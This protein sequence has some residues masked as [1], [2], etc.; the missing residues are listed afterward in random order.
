MSGHVSDDSEL[1]SLSPNRH[2]TS[3]AVQPMSDFD[4]FSL[5]CLSH[6]AEAGWRHT[7]TPRRPSE[8]PPAHRWLAAWRYRV[9]DREGNSLPLPLIISL[10]VVDASVDWQRL[11]CPLQCNPSELD[12]CEDLSD[13]QS[14]N[15]CG[16]LHTLTSR[17]KANMPLTQAG[18][19]LVN[20]WPPLQTNSKV[21]TDTVWRNH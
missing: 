14:V 20:F 8:G 18:P 12:L 3:A 2:L 4:C 11:H 1:F 21:K 9:W 16:I 5:T 6:S 13:L 7:W 10:N 19:N 15:E 17:A